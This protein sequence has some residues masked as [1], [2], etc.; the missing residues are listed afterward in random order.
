MPPLQGLNIFWHVVP[1]ACAVG[2]YHIAPPGLKTQ[3]LWVGM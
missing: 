1:T 2:Y 3:A